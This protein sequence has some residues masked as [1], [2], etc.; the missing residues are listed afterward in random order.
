MSDA[1]TLI[2]DQSLP[3]TFS[4]TQVV[5]RQALPGY[6]ERVQQR[7]LAEEIERSW[8]S[9]TILVG[10]AGTGTGKSLAYLIPA[11]LSD[12]R[13]VVTTGTKNLQA[14]LMDKDLPFLAEHLGVSF[15]FAMIQGKRN[16]FCHAKA[17]E[18]APGNPLIS[19][20]LAQFAADDEQHEQTGID[21]Q[22]DGLRENLIT[23][24][25]NTSWM[26]MTISADECPRKS[27][28]F[29]QVCRFERAKAKAY[30]A[31][32]VVANHA[33]VA[34]DG[35]IN[36]QSDGHANILGAFQHLVIDECHDFEGFLTNALTKMQT[37]G[38]WVAMTKELRGMIHAVEF[39][40]ADHDP[41]E[42]LCLDMK[43]NAEQ[44]FELFPVGRV[45]HKA[46]FDNA[47]PT[48]ALIDAL[49]ATQTILD[50][51]AIDNGEGM[52]MDD[53][54]VST[55]ARFNRMRSRLFNLQQGLSDF[56]LKTDAQVIRLFEE[57]GHGF[58][59]V[60]V[61]KVVPVRVDEW[62][63]DWLWS[64]VT[65]TLISATAL[66]DGKADFL[67]DQLGLRDIPDDGDMPTPITVIDVGSPFDF[68][69]QSLLY[70]PEHIAEPTPAKRAQWEREMLPLMEELVMISKGRALLLFTSR[71]QM[72]K[73][74]DAFA[75]KIPFPARKQGDASPALLT[76]WFREETNSV[77]FATRSF[78]QG[79]DIQG[80][81]LSL[82]VLD[83]L[84]FPS[85]VDPIFEARG[86][87]IERRGGS[88]FG[89]LSVP[90]MSLILQ[91]A[92]GR[93]IRTKLDYGVVAIMDPR[94]VTKNYGHKIRRSLPAPTCND[95]GD[96][97]SFFEAVP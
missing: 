14:Q 39:D 24:V 42:Q 52:P 38:S 16:Y 32:V 87:D 67:V 70:I 94:L 92:F 29:W 11:I 75:A 36:Q 82:V 33:L 8:E 84:P 22:L 18:N 4:E 6:E 83:K 77:L 86:E 65:P 50:Y 61:L 30:A 71:S 49:K 51:Y 5:L 74:W 60:K 69:R 88:S 46:A 59:R 41:I 76:R 57:E 91:Q 19:D 9:E 25:D 95:L 78:F 2:I 31:K 64:R 73:A 56:L 80:E 15:K 53:F 7:M 20:A 37:L 85:P 40:D 28:P 1:P 81:S 47:G 45:R 90:Q 17:V 35:V 58:N 34:L 12:G 10:Q 44:F 93:L 23:D 63:R 89:D 66:V 21:W 54:S 13:V 43:Y 97:E 68:K 48:T 55:K 3:T 72:D 79:I 26:N 27:C 62:A 96:V